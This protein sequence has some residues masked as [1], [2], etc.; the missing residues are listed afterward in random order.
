MKRVSSVAR[1]IVDAT[2]C[3]W[4]GPTLGFRTGGALVNSSKH[5]RR[6]VLQGS[7]LERPASV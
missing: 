4:L 2:S 7:Y 5:S 6:H 1:V 3:P